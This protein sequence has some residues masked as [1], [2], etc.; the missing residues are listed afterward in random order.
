MYRARN[1]FGIMAVVGFKSACLQNTRVLDASDSSHSSI[2][3]E[4]LYGFYKEQKY[5]DVTLKISD[6]QKIQVHRV[7]L[8]SASRYFDSLFGSQFQEAE[9]DE[10]KLPDFDRSIMN[11]LIEFVYSGNIRINAENVFALLHAANY[12]GV[13]FVEKSCSEF[14]K[15]CID[16]DS[17]L[18]ILQTADTFAL[19]H[20]RE[21]AK[22]HV[23]RH[24]ANASKGNGFLTL[25]CQLLKE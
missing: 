4:G 13:D 18:I 21:V 19:E 17:C 16:D 14:L 22:R 1:H 24:F 25:P 3:L 2:L 6:E 11:C 7:V 23:L 20:L 10:V 9:K 12:F 5:C 15:S 8:A